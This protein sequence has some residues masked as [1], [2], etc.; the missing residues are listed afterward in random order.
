MADSN[1]ILKV[2]RLNVPILKYFPIYFSSVFPESMFD[3]LS[4][5]LRSY[6]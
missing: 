4:K 5:I 2:R 1:E 3:L 6:L